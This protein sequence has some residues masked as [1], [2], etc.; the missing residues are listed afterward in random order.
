MKRKKGGTK[1]QEYYNNIVQMYTSQ[2]VEVILL[3]CS[4]EANFA[5]LNARKKM[6]RMLKV[7]DVAAVPEVGQK[8]TD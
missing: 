2:P 7:A 5:A 8:P 3:V 6:L 4:R 1:P